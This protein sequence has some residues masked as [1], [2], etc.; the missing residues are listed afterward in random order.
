[1]LSVPDIIIMTL[2]YKEVIA[3]MTD[4]ERQN[5]YAAIL[6]DPSDGPMYVIGQTCLAELRENYGF[7]G[8]DD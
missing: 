2:T 5:F 3:D 7:G 6:A 8:N 4:E 1:M